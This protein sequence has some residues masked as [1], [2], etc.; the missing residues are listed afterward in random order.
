MSDKKKPEQIF[1]SVE[2]VIYILDITRRAFSNILK[3]S[4]KQYV[5]IGKNYVFTK[6][7]VE[8]LKN[9][10]NQRRKRKKGK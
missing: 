1:Y 6:K 3:K 9:R 5:K 7:E 4:D 10:P 2:E 8:E